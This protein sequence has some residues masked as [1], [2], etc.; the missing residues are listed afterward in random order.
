MDSVNTTEQG[1]VAAQQALRMRR[2]VMGGVSYLFTLSMVAVCCWLGYFGL[3]VLRNYFVTVVLLNAAFY[4]AIR[5][6]VNLRFAD[7]SMTLVQICVS[8][9][10]GLYVVYHAQQA[11]G[12]L[13]LLCISAAMYG[14]FQF[15]TRDFIIVTALLVGG[16]GLLILYMYDHGVGNVNLQIELLR[17][18]ALLATFIQFSVLGGYIGSLRNKVKEKNKELAARNDDLEHAL[19]RIEE[20]AMRDELTGVFN[21]RYLMETIKNEKH[22]C[23]R[24][25][26]VFSI[27]ILD[28]D[29]FKQVNDSYGHLVGDEVLQAIATAATGALRQTDYFGRYGGEEF[30]LVL[31]ATTVE[32]AFITAE[33]VR[34]RI[35]ALRFPSVSAE[36]AVTV[37]IGIAD[38]R[39]N[40]ETALTFKRA[41][42]AL[43]KAKQNGRNRC[44]IATPALPV[45]TGAN[46]IPAET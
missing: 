12:V 25:G 30:A 40:E 18:C 45:P 11:R 43:Y 7:P 38:S 34:T 29:H 24:S 19:R 10:P 6:N 39:F 35:E 23:E 17:L 26:A 14:L 4:L 31:T 9:L 32:G 15:R 28:V 42:D 33:R 5:S 1:V 22:R 20:L 3:P 21:R 41:D 46:A 44:I 36:L 8:I 16:Y 13:L 2:M 27:C 37:S